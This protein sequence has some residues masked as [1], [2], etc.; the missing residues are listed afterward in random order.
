VVPGAEES[1]SAIFPTWFVGGRNPAKL[2]TRDGAKN[3][4]NNGIST[5]VP[6]TGEFTGF[7]FHQQY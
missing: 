7:L 4:V 5:T 3:P 1:W 2:T 6:S